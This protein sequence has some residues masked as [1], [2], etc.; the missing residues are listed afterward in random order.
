MVR[1]ERPP[2]NDTPY[3]TQPLEIMSPRNYA[4]SRTLLSLP[5][6]RCVS[7]ATMQDFS[8]QVEGHPFLRVSEFLHFDNTFGMSN[9]NM[10]PP[11]SV[12]D[13]GTDPDEAGE[14]VHPGNNWNASRGGPSRTGD[15]LGNP[16]EIDDYEEHDLQVEEARAYTHLR[17]E[18]PGVVVEPED[19]ENK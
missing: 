7:H 13:L 14:G 19:S 9:E 18:A 17:D 12:D 10:Q 1:F 2:R 6:K 8:S 5:E 4:A 16:D 15:L 11:W 3:E